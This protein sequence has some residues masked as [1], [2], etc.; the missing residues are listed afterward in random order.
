MLQLPSCFPPWLTPPVLMLSPPTPS[1]RYAASEFSSRANSACS[2]EAGSPSRGAESMLMLGAQE[3]SDSSAACDAA[4][5]ATACDAAYSAQPDT[6]AMVNTTGCTEVPPGAAGEGVHPMSGM[7][8]REYVPPEDSNEMT[9]AQAEGHAEGCEG[10]AASRHGAACAA[11]HQELPPTT[12]FE[13]EATLGVQ[14]EGRPVAHHPDDKQ[15]RQHEELEP[16]QEA[17]GHWAGVPHQRQQ[18]LSPSPSD[19][20]VIEQVCGVLAAQIVKGFLRMLA[21]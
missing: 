19:M 18:P 7:Q 13:A 2:S 14:H 12:A 6:P 20:A 16:A 11:G 3:A 5:A 17:C 4:A 8:V 10:R 1:C 21:L 15:Q 9:G